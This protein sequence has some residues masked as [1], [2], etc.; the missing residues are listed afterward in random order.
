M[1]TMSETP[2]ETPGG[3]VWDPTLRQWVGGSTSGGG[4]GGGG[5]S[6][7]DDLTDVAISSP[8]TG[9]VIAYNG[10][11][12]VNQANGATVGTNLYLYANFI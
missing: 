12:W 9:Q 8:S 6:T 11:A 7:L 2:N 5:A 1:V 3:E 10:S 4:T